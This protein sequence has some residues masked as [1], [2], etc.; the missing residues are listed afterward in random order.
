VPQSK[1]ARTATGVSSCEAEV[2]DVE[3]CIVTCRPGHEEQI[4]CSMIRSPVQDDIEGAASTVVADDVDDYQ[5]A[6]SGSGTH[7]E[8]TNAVT[9]A[10]GARS[11]YRDSGFNEGRP[12]ESNLGA[13]SDT[14]EDRQN[15]L[16]KREQEVCGSTAPSGS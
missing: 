15:E 11:R 5:L 10:R 6:S 12:Q 7:D 1:A 16:R 8:A 9:V 3:A 13:L 2:D 14:L 4:R